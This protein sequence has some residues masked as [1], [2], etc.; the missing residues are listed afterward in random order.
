MLM[1]EDVAI[2]PRCLHPSFGK[3]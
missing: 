3:G 2:S 1:E